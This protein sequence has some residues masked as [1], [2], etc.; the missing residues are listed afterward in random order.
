[1]KSTA[2]STSTTIQTSELDENGIAI[3]SFASGG[4]TVEENCVT[5]SD[6][7]GMFLG[8]DV[9]PTSIQDNNFVDND[10]FGI[11]YTGVNTILATNNWWA[12]AAGPQ[13]PN[14][15]GSFPDV[16]MGSGFVTTAPFLNVPASTVVTCSV[17]PVEL[18]KWEVL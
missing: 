5:R 13:G 16:D 6:S 8:D 17:L 3:Q 14:G 18:M 10:D 12:D 7:D 1:M 9:N 4:L 11:R 15:D 2:D